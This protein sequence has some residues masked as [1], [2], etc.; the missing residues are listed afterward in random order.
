M[1]YLVKLERHG[2][3][4]RGSILRCPGRTLENVGAITDRPQRCASQDISKEGQR[5]TR[6]GTLWCDFRPAGNQRLSTGQSHLMVRASLPFQKEKD[7][8][9]GW[10]FLFGAGDEARTRYLHLGKVA[11][12]RMSYARNEQNEL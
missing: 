4:R 9:F 7:Q 2:S 1:L 5:A 6:L 10:S 3:G 12:Y 11:L 8:P